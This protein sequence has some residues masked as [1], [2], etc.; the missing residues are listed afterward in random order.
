MTPPPLFSMA[1]LRGRVAREAG[2]FDVDE[3]G[4]HRLNP[5]IGDLIVKPELR[6]A[7]VLVPVVIQLVVH[8][9]RRLDAPS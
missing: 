8:G 6:A 9:G 2:P 3:H 4:D 5:T 1:D 7:A